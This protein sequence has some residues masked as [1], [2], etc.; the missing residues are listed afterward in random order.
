MARQGGGQ[1]PEEISQRLVI[2]AQEIAILEGMEVHRRRQR[3]AAFGQNPPA[4]LGHG[5]RLVEDLPSPFAQPEGELG[6]FAEGVVALVEDL[7]GDGDIDERLPPPQGRRTGGA[8]DAR[9]GGVL[10]AVGLSGSAIE[11]P[12]GPR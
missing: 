7:P 10:A 4:M 3:G 8:E 1:R 2:D 11:V 9:R 12:P 6:V 5:G